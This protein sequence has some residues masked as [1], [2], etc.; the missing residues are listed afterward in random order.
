MSQK[1]HSQD[2]NSDKDKELEEKCID[3][4]KEAAKADAFIFDE[5]E[6]GQ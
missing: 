3:A 5:Y 6:E 2:S 1:T 4:Y